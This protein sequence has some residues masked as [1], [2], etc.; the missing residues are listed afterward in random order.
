MPRHLLHIFRTWGAAVIDAVF[1]VRC[2]GCGR[3]V[4]S[5]RRPGHPAL[6]TEGS[7]EELR[8]ALSDFLCGTCS[9]L[10]RWIRSPLCTCCGRPFDAP[11]GVDHRC[12]ICGQSPADFSR[13]RAAAV[14]L[15]GFKALICAF[16]FQYRV[17]LAVPLSRILWRTL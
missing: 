8:A 4:G 1:P 13:A 16:K 9:R 12:G 5:G 6:K 2:H 11:Q 17:E 10:I 14:Y 3:L 7:D 15:G